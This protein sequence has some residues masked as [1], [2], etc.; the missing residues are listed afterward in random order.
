MDPHNTG[1]QAGFGI[2]SM[3]GPKANKEKVNTKVYPKYAM[4]QTIRVI[5]FDSKTDI[6]LLIGYTCVCGTFIDDKNRIL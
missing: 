5:T 6:D 3:G 2:S 1:R 4:P